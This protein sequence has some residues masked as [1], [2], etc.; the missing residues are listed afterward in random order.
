MTIYYSANTKGF[1]DTE[2]FNYVLPDELIEITKQQ[3]DLYV[4]EMNSNGKILVLVNGELS[5]VDKII[6]WDDI[7]PY[8]NMLLSDS[9]YTQLPDF[10][11]AKKMQWATY[12]QTLRDIP[13]TY[14]TPKEVIWPTPPA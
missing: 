3:R 12:R 8:R 9:D 11:E 2:A 6:T 1:Y 14:S 10:P 7:R 4:Q 5:L 13:Q